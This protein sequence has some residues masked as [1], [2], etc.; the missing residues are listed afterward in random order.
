M[1]KAAVWQCWAVDIAHVQHQSCLT[2]IDTAS[3]FTVWR[4]LQS[5][6]AQEVCQHFHQLFLELGSPESLMS[7]N[8]FV[9]RSREVV[10]LLHHWE[11]VQELSCTYHP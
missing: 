10:D 11:V 1:A 8:G 4:A 9:F 7:D 3:G 6:S 2:V 5:E